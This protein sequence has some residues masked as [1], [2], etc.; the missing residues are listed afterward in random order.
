MTQPLNSE[1]FHNDEQVIE[2]KRT[3]LDALKR[4]QS[5]LTGVRPPDAE[6]ASTYQE[7]IATFS[8]MR[9]GNLYFPFLGSGIGNGSLVELEDGSVKYDFINGIGVHHL[10]HSHPKVVAAALDAALSDTIMQ[11]NLQQNHESVT[12]SKT[13]IDAAKSKGSA[14]DHCFLTATGVM[15][16]E[17]ALKIA[18]QKK[19]PASRVMAFEGCFAGRTM[20]F[21]QIT[22]KPNF[23]QGL[24]GTLAVDYVPFCDVDHPQESA[25]RSAGVIRNH[26][27]R[28]PG[29]HA[30]MIFELVQGEGG[31]N[32]GTRE[33]HRT[34]MELLKEHGIAVLVDEVQTFARTPE[35]FAFQYYGL[36][37]LVDIVWIGKASQVCA[38]LFKDE[39]RP[40]PGLLSQT[41]TG[42][43]SAI[44]AGQVMI[45]ELLNGGYFGPEG[46]IVKLHEHFKQKLEGISSRHPDRLTGPY[47]I[48]MM[49]A[50]TPLQGDWAKVNEFVKALYHNGLMAFIAGSNPA[51]VR[52]LL[53]AGAVTV[54][55]L[56]RAAKI[57]EETLV[58]M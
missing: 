24:P 3:I 19:Y 26:I 11:G 42:S 41:F 36:D 53:P 15:A 37:D 25:C 28:Y 49:V 46:K 18:M 17:N 32:V 39:F 5:Q 16:G 4:H 27:K 6:R 12:L 54:E 45:D 33:F 56:D 43:S 13:L 2:A 23:R 1:A 7:L 47:G 21:S 10:G 44:A 34:L 35:L 9:G 48:G 38:T 14:L 57:I 8:E 51:R 58:A 55:E 50:T 31:F 40:K 30:A 20:T 22:D 29:Q 52:F